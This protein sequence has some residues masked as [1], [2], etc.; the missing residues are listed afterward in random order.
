M[1]TVGLAACTGSRKEERN[2]ERKE[3]VGSTGWQQPR[4]AAIFR[5]P[6]FIGWLHQALSRGSSRVWLA[7]RALLE[8]KCHPVKVYAPNLYRELYASIV[9]RDLQIRFETAEDL[10]RTAHLPEWGPPLGPELP[11][12]LPPTTQPVPRVYISAAGL[13]PHARGDAM[14]HGCGSSCVFTQSA[15]RYI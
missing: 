9:K 2:K 6:V 14:R 11:T 7:S 4:S 3:G 15:P 8:L 12:K 5:N 10:R 13:T 1:G